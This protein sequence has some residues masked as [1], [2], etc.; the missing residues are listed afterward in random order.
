MG[1]GA[2]AGLVMGVDSWGREEP[3]GVVRV[4]ADAQ[5]HLVNY[6]APLWVRQAVTVLDKR[7]RR[8]RRGRQDGLCRVMSSGEG[9]S[10]L[11][12][13]KRVRGQALG[14]RGRSARRVCGAAVPQVGKGVCVDRRGDVGVWTQRPVVAVPVFVAVVWH[15][16]LHLRQKTHRRSHTHT[17]PHS[18]HRC[19]L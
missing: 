9:A 5:G 2:I 11:V 6:S 3:V 12:G 13:K 17:P 8:R 14:V 18:P 1:E 10:R 4:S 16:E 15:V 19:F 7:G